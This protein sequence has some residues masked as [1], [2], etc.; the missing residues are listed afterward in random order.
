MVV[1]VLVL[2]MIVLVITT[3]WRQLWRLA[4]VPFKTFKPGSKTAI[5]RGYRANRVLHLPDLGFWITSQ[6]WFLWPS[7]N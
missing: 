1:T 7:R 6:F 4:V 2:P 3:A 5:S